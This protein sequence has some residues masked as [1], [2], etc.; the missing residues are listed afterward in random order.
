M[1]YLNGAVFMLFVLHMIT[2]LLVS[3][4]VIFSKKKRLIREVSA[5]YFF[6]K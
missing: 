6:H 2:T 5:S 4:Q 1:A 3:S